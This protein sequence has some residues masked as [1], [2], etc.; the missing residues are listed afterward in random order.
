MEK[1]KNIKIK[2]LIIDLDMKSKDALDFRCDVIRNEDR[3]LMYEGLDTMRDKNEL[4]I[5]DLTVEKIIRCISGGIKMD[6]KIFIF[7]IDLEVYNEVI[8][9]M[10][11]LGFDNNFFTD[12][13]YFFKPL[14]EELKKCCGVFEDELNEGFFS[15]PKIYFIN[16]FN[17]ESKEIE[18][19]IPFE[20][21]KFFGN[22]Y[23]SEMGGGEIKQNIDFILENTAIY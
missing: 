10:E 22:T 8:Y 5:L 12:K 11:N 15:K 7:R 9:E 19:T 14:N 16:S 1:M 6:M 17:C 2:D 20:Y 23:L 18:K 4:L 21:K 3:I 13:T